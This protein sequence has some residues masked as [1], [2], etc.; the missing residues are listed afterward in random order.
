MKRETQHTGHFP[1][2]MLP[3]TVIRSGTE[4]LEAHL[5]RHVAEVMRRDVPTLRCSD[6]LTRA[7]H[8]IAQSGQQ[9]LPVLDDADEVAGVLNETDLRRWMHEAGSGG[10]ARP[11]YDLLA[12][13]DVMRPPDTSVS[14]MTSIRRAIQTLR[15]RHS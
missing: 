9:C 10:I 7:W 1:G 3:A 2:R 4:R 14:P 8:V 5:S 12:V 15:D 11:W 6:S 13:E